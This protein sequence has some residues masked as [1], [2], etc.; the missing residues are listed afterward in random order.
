[1]TL[2]GSAGEGG[3]QILRSALTLAAITGLPFRLTRVRANRAKTGLAAQHLTCV[4]AAAA[5]T[6]AQVRGASLGSSDLEFH[7]GPVRPGAYHFAVGTAGATP[8][9]LQTV[10]LPLMHAVNGPSEVTVDGGTHVAHAPCLDYLRTT[11]SGY[12]TAAGFAPVL[13][14]ARPGFYPRGGGTLHARLPPSTAARA[15]TL[16]TPVEVRTAVVLSVVAGELPE[17]VATRQA[18]RL[19][20]RLAEVGVAATVT[21]ERWANGPSSLA[22]VTCAD[23]PVPTLFV[24][25]GERG[26]PAERVADE[27]FAEFAAWAATGCPVDPHAADQLLLPLVLAGGPSEYRVSAVTQHLLTN[28]D[29]VRHFVD[30]AIT[31]EGRLGEPGVVRVAAAGVESLHPGGTPA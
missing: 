28:V 16:V 17:T 15:L 24:A 25:L 19:V 26:K 4:R 5:V 2:D 22:A 23:G 3:G 12:L 27:A 10:A 13:T 20:T 18:D 29:T 6:A 30:R 9:V 21:I 7:P 11:W 1:M 31:V 14:M 8:L